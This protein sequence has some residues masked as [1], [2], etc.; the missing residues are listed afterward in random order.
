MMWSDV[1][2]LQALDLLPLGLG[3]HLIAEQASECREAQPDFGEV[4]ADFDRCMLVLQTAEDQYQVELG[5]SRVAQQALLAAEADLRRLY[6]QVRGRFVV[7]TEEGEENEHLAGILKNYP[8]E[9]RLR[10]HALAARAKSLLHSAEPHR[11][12]LAGIGLPA[13]LDRLAVG[14]DEFQRADL[15]RAAETSEDKV[16]AAARNTATAA[17]RTAI[18]RLV[19][20]L[21][22]DGNVDTLARLAGLAARHLPAGRRAAT[23]EAEAGEQ[24]EALDGEEAG[25]NEAAG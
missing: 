8:R 14:L 18:R 5:E 6:R 17:A 10:R 23:D 3:L 7:A 15:H 22:L 25:D 16:A 21:E 24:D 19:V 12:S 13:A 9:S 2:E 11:A 4:F 20:R 1:Q